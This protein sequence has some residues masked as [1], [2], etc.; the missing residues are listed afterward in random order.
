M[1]MVSHHSPDRKSNVGEVGAPEHRWGK[2]QRRGTLPARVGEQEK[3][4]TAIK[5]SWKLFQ[6]VLLS[7]QEN[8]LALKS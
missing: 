7:V 4:A 5:P 2:G 8:Q 3:A 6:I 1:E